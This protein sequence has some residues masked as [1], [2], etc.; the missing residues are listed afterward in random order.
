MVGG[1]LAG[2][3]AAARV[4]ELG[5]SC[6]VFT[7]PVAGGL[8]LSIEAI[9]D[10][11]GHPDGVPGYDLCPMTQEAAMDHGADCVSEDATVSADGDRWRVRGGD[12]EVLARAVI[13]APGA[14]LRA[15]DVPGEARLA[16]RGVS[17]CASCDAPL[18]RGKPV[19]VVGGG[20]AACQEA[21]TLAAH[22][23]QVHLLVRGPSLRAQQKW[24]QRIAAEPKIA[25]RYGAQL[26]EIAGESGVQAVRLADGTTL[27]VDGVFVYAGLVPNTDA[28]AGVVALDADARIVADAGLCTAAP[29]A[30]A[31]GVARSGH[32]GQAADAAADGIAAAQAA[33]RFLDQPGWPIV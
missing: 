27:A 2:L 16:G 19:V 11:P 30:F 13:L 29:G 33:H 28:L 26:A 20:D 24:Q 32:S 25:V 21:L 23:S 8:L 7:G 5:R 18:L 14:R 6:T 12:T 22:A 3:S 4:A 1:G 15:L 9:E 17:H 31:A 10:M